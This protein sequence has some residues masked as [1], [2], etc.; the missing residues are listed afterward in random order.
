MEVMLP[1][2]LSVLLW[3]GSAQKEL[4]TT[5]AASVWRARES[6]NL[7]RRLCAPSPAWSHM[8]RLPCF[9]ADLPH[10]PCF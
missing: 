2:G 1:L 9:P 10:Q 5:V 3:R 7:L 4:Q 8:A 6:I